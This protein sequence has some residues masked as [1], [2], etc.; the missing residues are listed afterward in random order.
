[1]KLNTRFMAKTFLDA[2]A[3]VPVT[4]QLTLVTLLISIPLGFF[5]ALGRVEK[6][7]AGR[8]IGG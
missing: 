2:L 1:M 8:L 3:G 7:A 6:K 5:M 4:L